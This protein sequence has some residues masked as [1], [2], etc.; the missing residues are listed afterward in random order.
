M[1]FYTCEFI[2]SFPDR[3]TLL[4]MAKVEEGRK[5]EGG[6]TQTNKNDKMTEMQKEI[7]ASVD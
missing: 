4:S 3:R 2:P 1:I 5:K 6:I 7:A